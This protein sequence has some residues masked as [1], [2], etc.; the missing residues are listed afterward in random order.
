MSLAEMK[1][2]AEKEA[3]KRNQIP[4]GKYRVRLADWEFGKTQKRKLDQYVLT[5][6]ILKVI[7][8]DEE[9]DED[10]NEEDVKGKKR[11]TRYMTSES[12]GIGPLLDILAQAGADL[13]KYDKVSDIDTILEAI[14]DTK[15]PKAVLTYEH[16]EGEQ[17]P[18]TCDIS[19]VENVLGGLD[20][21]DEED[22]DDEED[23]ESEEETPAPKA[24]AKRK[25]KAPR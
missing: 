5:W 11:K 13:E 15:M 10:F 6:K 3:A 23:E 1:A 17:Y 20:E 7:E 2:S 4:D 18:K 21:E 24:A 8:L 22:D 14:E 25:P 16:P 9:Q 19:E 12:W